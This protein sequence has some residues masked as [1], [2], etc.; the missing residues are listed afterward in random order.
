MQL[1]SPQFALGKVAGTPK[2]KG[3]ALSAGFKSYGYHLK[4]KQRTTFKHILFQD[5]PYVQTSAKKCVF[6]F[7]LLAR[8]FENFKPLISLGG[9]NCRPSSSAY[10]SFIFNYL[11]PKHVF[12]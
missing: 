11:Y 1:G 8:T 4:A 5:F 3:K 9:N 7:Y 6:E 10:Y 12:W 2:A